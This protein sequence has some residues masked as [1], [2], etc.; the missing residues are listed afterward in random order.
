MMTAWEILQLQPYTYTD[1]PF[2]LS[3]V[4]LA[5]F[6]PSCCFSIL[7][8]CSITLVNCS[9]PPQRVRW[10]HSHSPFLGLAACKVLYNCC[11]LSKSSLMLVTAF[12]ST[13]L[14]VSPRSLLAVLN[15]AEVLVLLGSA[16]VNGRVALTSCG[17]WIHFLFSFVP[18]SCT[19][20]GSPSLGVGFYLLQ[21]VAN[22]SSPYP[23]VG[24]YLLQSIVL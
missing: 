16:G 6:I 24:F 5:L 23:G 20:F 11:I 12:G 8:E 14:P 21:A 9:G 17:S 18:S 4:S 13:L 15:H 2:S 10:F 1:V 7:L 19:L 3:W 22:F